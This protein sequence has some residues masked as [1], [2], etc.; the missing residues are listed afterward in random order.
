MLMLYSVLPRRG[1]LTYT[2]DEKKKKKKRR[3]EEEL[4]I[5]ILWRGVTCLGIPNAS[6]LVGVATREPFAQ[7][8]GQEKKYQSTFSTY[9]K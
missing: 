3:R 8:V 7:H 4:I 6:A 5:T 9:E 2:D 1:L